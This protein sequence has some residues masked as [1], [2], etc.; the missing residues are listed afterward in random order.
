[1]TL[2]LAAPAR[3]GITFLGSTRIPGDATDKSGLTDILKDGTPNNR[4]G[5]MGSGIAYTGTGNRYLLV[6]DRGPGDGSNNY[7]CPMQVM[8]IAVAV[9]ASPVVK[10]VL[11]ATTLLK[12]EQ[13]ASFVGL[14]SALDTADP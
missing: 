14:S 4:L 11:V 10:Q 9:G 8:D 1:M 3:A 7:H 6:A 5:G 2:V 13:G 12:N